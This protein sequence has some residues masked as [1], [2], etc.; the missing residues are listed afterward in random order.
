ML[1]V[2]TEKRALSQ[3]RSL[4]PLY[5]NIISQVKGNIY[6]EINEKIKGIKE[7]NYLI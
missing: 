5:I 2:T 6:R 7:S 3:S 1:T 4:N